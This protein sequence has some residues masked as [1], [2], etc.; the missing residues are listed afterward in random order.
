M[1]GQS[2]GGA[3]S[4]GGD[5][6]RGRGYSRGGPP[7]SS[8]PRG[9]SPA[10]TV[11]FPPV[12]NK[13]PLV[14]IGINL[15]HKSY[16]HDLDKIIQR[17]KDHS[18]TL[19]VITG[20]CE[21]R[22]REALQ[23]SGKYD[24]CYATAGVHPH[25]A[26]SFTEQ[27]FAQLEKFC[28]NKKVVAVGE[29]GLDYDRMFSPKDKQQEV[30][31]QQINLAVKVGKPLFLHERDAF[32]DFSTILEKH[33]PAEIKACVHCFTGTKEQLLKYIELGCYIGITGWV[34]D[35]KRGA[36][37]QQIVKLIPHDKIMIETD[38]PF[39]TPKDM[40][41]EYKVKRNEPCFLPFVLKKLAPLMGLTEQA[42]AEHTTT[43]AK[44]FFGIE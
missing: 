37:L 28:E 19:L 44:V 22:S 40:P 20:T 27:T 35:N 31:I 9:G 10:P 7:P 16:A 33:K 1:D 25:D 17:S 32:Q 18:V 38:G 15:S 21:K 26:K 2:R 14:D 11:T 36:E 39:L 34:N 3:W 24:C 29:C 13:F 41:N 23:L 42:L 30:F 6:G 8:S 12:T 4:R 43:N 5:R